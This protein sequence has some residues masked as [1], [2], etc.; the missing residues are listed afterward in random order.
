[1]VL[2]HP[3]STLWYLFVNKFSSASRSPKGLVGGLLQ[4]E[5][6]P[7]LGSAWGSVCGSV[8]VSFSFVPRYTMALAATKGC[9]LS[10]S[11][12]P[13]LPGH[14]YNWCLQS[15]SYTGSRVAAR[16]G[17]QPKIPK[18]RPGTYPACQVSKEPTAFCLQWQKLD[19]QGL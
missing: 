12:R 3:T 8:L 17:W 5:G 2:A 6:L 10:G 18:P 1:M 9:W 16:Q 13:G 4:R 14:C 7:G 19:R 11:K 15:L